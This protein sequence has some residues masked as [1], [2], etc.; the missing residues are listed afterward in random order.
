[1]TFTIGEKVGPYRIL[2]QIGKGSMATVFKAYQEERKRYVAL[3]VL[4]P[5][6]K[7]DPNFLGRFQREASMV[8]KLDHP[9][10]IPFYDYAEYK[11]FPYLVMKFIEGQTLKDRLQKGPLN[12]E[13]ILKITRTVGDGLTYAHQQGILHRDVKPS[14][15]LLANDGQI[16]LADFGLARL[17]S[18]NDSTLSAEI[19]VGTPQYLSPEQASGITDLDVRSDVYNL[20]VMLYEMTVGQVP[21]NS[22][23][24]YKVVLDHIY[25]P[26]PLPREINLKLSEEIE[27]VLLKA[28]AKDRED[29]YPDVASLVEAFTAALPR[30][31]ASPDAPPTKRTMISRA[32]RPADI[33]PVAPNAPAAGKPGKKRRRSFWVVVAWVGLALLILLIIITVIHAGL[34]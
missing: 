6:F 2:E 15:V 30:S 17:A 22:D 4:H 13:E 26:L 7:E 29:R 10:I 3:K 19:L 16:Y 24:P 23:T 25:K 1:L 14:N 21:F 18:A 28:L 20:G 8:A 34:R 27:R 31:G 12:K 32:N 9:N 33:L 11:G 5:A